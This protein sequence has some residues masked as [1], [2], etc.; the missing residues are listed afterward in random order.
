M[1]R[2]RPDGACTAFSWRTRRPSPRLPDGLRRDPASIPLAVESGC[3]SSALAPAPRAQLL[4]CISAAAGAEQTIEPF[5][6]FTWR[7]GLY[8][9][10]RAA[11]SMEAE[12]QLWWRLK[13]IP[14]PDGIEESDLP[15]LLHTMAMKGKDSAFRLTDDN[16]RSADLRR[17]TLDGIMEYSSPSGPILSFAETKMAV[18]VKDGVFISGVPFSLTAMLSMLPGFGV[19]SP[20]K[21]VTESSGRFTFPLVLTS[22]ELGTSSPLLRE[23]IADIYGLLAEKYPVDGVDGPVRGEDFLRGPYGMKG[24][25]TADDDHGNRLSAS[26]DRNGMFISYDD[27]A[28]EREM[29]KVY[30]DFIVEEEAKKHASRTDR[31]AEL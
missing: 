5:G 1:L 30:E 15:D 29:K 31:S 16:L 2:V 9:V 12:V 18:V 22:V 13:S 8:E 4:L 14:I 3:L 20:E 11:D 19:D 27:Y 28:V 17:R 24:M 10:I 7:S 23:G 25:F 26:S 21:T 6:S